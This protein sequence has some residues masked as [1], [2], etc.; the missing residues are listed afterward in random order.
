M[1]SWAASKIIWLQIFSG[2]VSM[3]G[4]AKPVLENIVGHPILFDLAHILS[5]Q[6]QEIIATII[7]FI[8]SMFTVKLRTTVSQP[9]KTKANIQKYKGTFGDGTA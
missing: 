8:V 5:P 6:I 1:K 7:V 2:L 3:F 9:I 4:I